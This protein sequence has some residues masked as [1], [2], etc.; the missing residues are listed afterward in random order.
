MHFIYGVCNANSRIAVRKYQCK[1]FNGRVAYRGVFPRCRVQL[2]GTESFK[3]FS[4]KN[5]LNA[6]TR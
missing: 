1:F 5:Q 6:A 3:L 2:R 4:R